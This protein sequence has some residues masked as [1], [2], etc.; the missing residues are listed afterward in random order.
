MNAINGRRGMARL[1]GSPSQRSSTPSGPGPGTGYPWV[2]GD[3]LY[4]A[5]LN[6]AVTTAGGTTPVTGYGTDIGQALGPLVA[7]NGHPALFFNDRWIIGRNNPLDTDFA[8][9]HMVRNTASLVSSAVNNQN[10]VLRLLQ[11]IGANDQTQNYALQITTLGSGIGGLNYGGFISSQ[12]LAGS[13]AITVGLNAGVTDLNTG[14]SS[15]SGG[16]IIAFEVHTGAQTL[17]DSPNARA[18]GGVGVRVGI[19][20]TA[21]RTTPTSSPNPALTPPVEIA[22]GIWVGA[23]SLDPSTQPPNPP[24]PS[25]P[26]TYFD[27]VLGFVANTQARIVVDTR[28]MIKPTSSTDPVSAVTMTAGHIIDFNGSAS[29]TSNPGRELSAIPRRQALLRRGRCRYVERRCVRQRARPRHRHPERHA[30]SGTGYPWQPGEP[31]LAADLNAAIA[32]SIGLSSGTLPLNGSLPMTGPLTLAGNATLP[33]HAVPLQQ[34]TSAV[35]SAPFLPLNGSAPMTGPLTLFADPVAALGAATKQYVDTRGGNAISVSPGGSIQAAH[36]A[37]PSTGGSILLAANTT[38]I[39]TAQINITK[40]NVHISAP[41]WSTIVRRA[42]GFTTGIVLA[43]VGAGAII[44]GFTIDGNAAADPTSAEL[45]VIGDRSLVRGMQIVNSTGQIHLSLMGQHSRATGNTITGPGTSF[46]TQVG[47]GIWAINHNTVMIDHNVIT[48]TNIDAIGFDGQGTQII[49]NWVAGCH[50]WTGGPGGQIAAYYATTLGQGTS[51]S[52]IDN[53]IG[54]PGALNQGTGIESWAPGA[55]I[56]GNSIEGCSSAITVF[57]PGATIT[58]NNIRNCGFAPPL[59]AVVVV[60]NVTDFVI[61]GNRIA[62]DQTT[63]TMRSGISI[64]AGTSNRYAITGNQIAGATFPIQDQ[65]TGT[66]KTIAD[67]VGADAVVSGNVTVN[68]RLTA[69]GINGPIGTTTPGTGAFT[70]INATGAV[71]TTGQVKAA[72]ELITVFGGT[73]PTAVPLS[74]LDLVGSGASGTRQA[75][76]SAGGTSAMVFRSVGGTMGAPT[77]TPSNAVMGAIYATGY[78]PTAGWGTTALGSIQFL[79]AGLWSDTSQPV[80]IQF[81]TTAIGATAPVEAMRVSPNGNLLI[82]GSTDGTIKL[83]VVGAARFNGNLG[84]YNTAPVAKPTVSGA[85]GSNAA[86]GSLI[87]ALVS[88]GLIADTTTA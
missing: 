22:H 17:D 29:L 6:A 19:H 30:V 85:K 71:T 57:T 72:S 52:I 76:T 16:G 82:G 26:Y 20:L 61:S 75:I 60:A 88:Q 23:S 37:L 86:L 33:L 44:E 38:Y 7:S 65:G 10:A 8:N 24:P 31:L 63:P 83:D 47:Y 27:S 9:V 70:T 58:G 67:N 69:N 13:G 42:P 50:C 79:A 32:N 15:T 14:P 55:I 62:D 45:R 1:G 34:L 4:A 68:G 56:S 49:G 28:G 77:P 43:V 41:S 84:F 35:A 11:S 73:L 12:K 2:D 53:Y 74:L 66:T 51:S 64:Y 3:W 81:L 87:A 39:V 25:D 59:D 78:T 54:P 21:V 46:G 36:D 18:F 48:G 5:D 80:S 40:P